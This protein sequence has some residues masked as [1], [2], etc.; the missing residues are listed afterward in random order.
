VSTD[1]RAGLLDA[2]R[3]TPQL[4]A[5]AT[6]RIADG[7][8]PHE[9]PGAWST[10]EVVTHLVAVDEEIWRARLEQLAADEHPRWA[11][12]QPDMTARMPISTR[13]ALAA[14]EA[15]RAA[16]VERAVAMDA[17]AWRHTGTH[18]VFGE[19]D[20]EGLLREALKHDL[21]HVEDLERRATWPAPGAADA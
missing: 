3:R 6:A 13:E 8:A 1:A 19:L 21:E 10:I 7:A 15:G 16:L 18:A 5:D 14:F 4:V 12:T 20:V 2:V 17:D 9:P 11:W